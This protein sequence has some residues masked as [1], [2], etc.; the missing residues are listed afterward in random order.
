MNA[1]ILAVA[2]LI[3]SRLIASDRIEPYRHKMVSFIN[4]ITY[5]LPKGLQLPIIVCAMVT[6]GAVIAYLP[7][8]GTVAT[9]FTLVVT[10]PYGRVTE[11]STAILT[12]LR[13]GSL[14]QAQN[15]LSDFSGTDAS[16]LDENGV[17][18]IAVESA[19]L[20]LAEQVFIPLA[21]FALGGLPGLLLYWSSSVISARSGSGDTS[22]RWISL[23]NWIP[24]RLMALTL[25]FMGER[26]RSRSMWTREAHKFSDPEAGILIAAT[27]GALRVKLGGSRCIQGLIKQEPIVGE[28][29]DAAQYHIKEILLLAER[30]LL[31]WAVAALVIT[32]I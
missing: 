23:L 12:E 6:I 19:V 28:A 14:S 27:A 8:F 3:F 21:W 17:A 16:Q 26:E 30:A 15:E 24:I 7:L 1:L 13:N 20:N 2:A 32:A 29:D 22:D 5:A 9:F 4:N 31:L 18:R 25:G 10:L 11:A